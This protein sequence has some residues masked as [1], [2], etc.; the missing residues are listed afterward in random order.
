MTRL[1]TV[2][3]RL[4]PSRW[5]GLVLF[6]M[7]GS[8]CL[9]ACVS[10]PETGQRRVYVPPAPAHAPTR[11]EPGA[12][13]PL[14]TPGTSSTGSASTPRS[15]PTRIEDTD[16]NAAVIALYRQAAQA[17]QDGDVQRA[18][19]DLE[20]ALRLAPANAFVWSALAGVHLQAGKFDQVEGEASK[21]NALA[22]AN[23]VLLHAN[24]LAIASARKSLGDAAGAAEAQQH[25][26]KYASLATPA[27]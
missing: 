24:W 10:T 26:E 3:A 18:A 25:A 20:R 1:L 19:S 12:V 6:I 14:T 2:P 21:S 15:Y 8:L 16:A 7:A 17:R 22:G 11:P 9:S 13:A 4:S 23:P 5:Q 27:Q